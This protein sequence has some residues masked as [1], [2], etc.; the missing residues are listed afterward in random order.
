MPSQ[1]INRSAVPSQED[2]QTVKAFAKLA[3]KAEAGFET[4]TKTLLAV[5]IL[6]S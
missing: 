6:S 5:V 1:S 2:K 4:S 3:F